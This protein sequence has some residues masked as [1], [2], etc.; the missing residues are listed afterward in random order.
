MH[1]LIHVLLVVIFVYLIPQV[2]YLY[3]FAMTLTHT[4]NILTLFE[5]LDMNNNIIL[6]II[7]GSAI[8]I[9]FTSVGIMIL[10]LMVNNN[11][12]LETSKKLQRVTQEQTQ[13]AMQE[14]FQNLTINHNCDNYDNVNS[15]HYNLD[16][17]DAMIS[18]CEAYDVIGYD[19]QKIDLIVILFYI[20]DIVR[21]GFEKESYDSL[22]LK[23][24]MLIVGIL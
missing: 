12:I 14:E 23:T 16:L 20:F 10:S 2:L 9:I 3:D 17:I 22:N 1:Q 18:P 15:S 19:L 6:N 7:S 5:F 11:I 21:P 4:L 8:L 13:M 24:K